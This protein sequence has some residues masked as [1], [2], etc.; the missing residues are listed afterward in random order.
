MIFFLY[1]AIIILRN[2]ENLTDEMAEQAR[3]DMVKT[4]G[5]FILPNQLFVNVRKQAK[6]DENLNETLE[7][8]FKKEQH[9]IDYI[10][11]NLERKQRNLICRRVR[12]CRKAN[13][14][15]FNYFCT[16]TY[17]NKLHTEESFKKS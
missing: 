17:D 9:C 16:F 10:N 3:E 11:I 13:L 5:F 2:Y 1:Y 14:A 8:I 7:K 15:N 6:T 12:M 4:K